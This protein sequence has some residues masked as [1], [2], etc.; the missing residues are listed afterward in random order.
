[1]REGLHRQQPLLLL[2]AGSSAGMAAKRNARPLPRFARSFGEGP[3]VFLTMPWRTAVAIC[4]RGW[5]G[6]VS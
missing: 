3:G 6:I 5:G 4:V 2:S 1:M